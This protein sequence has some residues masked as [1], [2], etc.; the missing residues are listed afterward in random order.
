[1]ARP[2]SN[3]APRI[4]HAA[5]RRFLEDGVDGA[6]LRQIAREAKTNLGMVYYYF[7]NKDDL[8]LAVV[9]EVYAGLLRDLAAVL[10]PALPFE[11]RVRALY[12]RLGALSDDEFTVVRLVMR[13]AMV[14]SKR[15]GRVLARFKEGHIGYVIQ[16]LADGYQTGHV[17]EDLEPTALLPCLA[18]LVFGVVF[19]RRIRDAVK[20]GAEPAWPPAPP[21]EVAKVAADFVL[22]GV[23]KDA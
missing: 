16:T 5:R 13:E 9:E 6:S 20:D 12:A 10:D 1:L 23:A 3:I 7:P 19:A 4:V 17:R 14:S 18:G 8:F 21:A 22:R 11:D 2:R 15:L